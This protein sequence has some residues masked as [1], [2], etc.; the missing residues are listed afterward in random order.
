V[1]DDAARLAHFATLQELE[2][3]R[4]RVLNGIRQFRRTLDKWERSVR[5]GRE[6]AA[7]RAELEGLLVDRAE[8]DVLAH[9]AEQMGIEVPKE[10]T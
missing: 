4:H 9:L 8:W 7:G 2:S 1:T 5:A 3:R 6:T 10:K